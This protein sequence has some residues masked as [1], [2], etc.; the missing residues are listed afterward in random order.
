[1]MPRPVKQQAAATEEARK[2]RMRK[3]LKRQA[4]KAKK[5]EAKAK[6]QEATCTTYFTYLQSF[7]WPNIREPGTIRCPF[8]TRISMRGSFMSLLC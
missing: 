8:Y 2:T 5:E 4:A 7:V 1:M 6:E 3:K